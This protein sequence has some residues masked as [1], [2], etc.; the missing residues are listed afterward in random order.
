MADVFAFLIFVA[1]FY[2]AA[3]IRQHSL[4]ERLLRQQLALPRVVRFC[5]VEYCLDRKAGRYFAHTGGKHL[6]LLSWWVMVLNRQER[7]V[8][9]ELFP[10][11]VASIEMGE[12][13]VLAGVPVRE[14]RDYDPGDVPTCN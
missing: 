11:F 13:P 14:V 6:S 10:E 7:K 1:P 5:G 4:D 8:W 3:K 12:S 9:E 2:L